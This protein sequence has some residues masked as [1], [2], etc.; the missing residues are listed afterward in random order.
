VSAE[1]HTAGL[2]ATR[3]ASPIETTLYRIAQEALTNIAKH[4]RATHVD[5]LLERRA[6]HVSLIIEDDGV[7]FASAASDS[8]G[9][10]GLLGMQE[11]A[12]LIG[13]TLQVESAPG[14]GTTIL[15]RTP[16]AAEVFDHAV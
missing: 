1:L 11:R 10:A 12:A 13:A 16:I 15:V 5:I 4:A 2:T 3:V 6:D 9:G 14:R 7:G 8:S